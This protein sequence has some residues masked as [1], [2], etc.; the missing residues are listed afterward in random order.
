[1]GG[2]QIHFLLCVPRSP[3]INLCLWTLKD[4]LRLQVFPRGE[5]F[6]PGRVGSAIRAAVML[7]G[8]LREKEQRPSCKLLMPTPAHCLFSASHTGI[9]IYFFILFQRL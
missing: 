4:H 9:L 6:T 7:G 8:S 1:M 2:G 5:P 3:P